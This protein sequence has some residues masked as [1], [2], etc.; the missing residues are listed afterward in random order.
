MTGGCVESSC[1]EEVCVVAA[2]AAV[3]VLWFV[4]EGCCESDLRNRSVVRSC[5]ETDVEVE[6]SE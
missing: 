4:T 6:G 3:T 1:C 2:L 5:V